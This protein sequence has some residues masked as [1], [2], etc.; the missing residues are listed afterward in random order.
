MEETRVEK[1]K[2]YR[3]SF[4]SEGSLVSPKKEMKDMSSQRLITT[5]TLPLDQVL[6]SIAQN[7]REAAFLRRR[8]INRI[9]FITGVS[10]I[11]ISLIALLIV[12][13]I[14]VFQG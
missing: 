8:K 9:M 4:V 2:K 12:F 3:Q 13:G 14:I 11:S 5:S 1:Y 6:N 10:I 7:E